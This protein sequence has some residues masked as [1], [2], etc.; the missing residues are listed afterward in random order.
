[1]ELFSSWT[2]SD[3]LL[4]YSVLLGFAGLGAWWMP[5]LLREPGRRAH[6]DDL[7]SVAVLAGGASRLTD[8]LL[9]ELY[10]NGAV[11]EGP[12]GKLIFAERSVAVPSP[13]AQALVAAGE[14]MSRAEAKKALA[15]HAARIVARL[16]RAGLLMRD[17]EFARLRW[18]A[19][20]PFA[21]LFLLGIYRQRAGDAAGEPTG[22][23]VILLVLTAILALARFFTID[24]R[25]LAGVA[26]VS[27]LRARHDRFSR[28]PMPDEAAMAVALFGTTVLIGTPWELI[29][30]LRKPESDGGGSGG[31]G[32]SDGGSG[33]GGGGCGG[34]G[35]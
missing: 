18:L 23:L 13:G 32:G 29:H 21:A 24:P 10:V 35:G 20:T 11:A 31:D 34:C 7:E 25:T 19:V 16:Q 14:P 22:F 12:K 27:D 3:F 30:G 4:F 17:P 26:A 8:S 1:M 6:L 5:S 33:C 28:A 2:G 15:I 9:A